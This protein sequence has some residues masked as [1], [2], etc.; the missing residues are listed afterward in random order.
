MGACCTKSKLGNVA[1]AEQAV[2]LSG[3]VPE[4]SPTRVVSH[5]SMGSASH[6]M[7][8]ITAE[9]S[10]VLAT[11]YRHMVLLPRDSR[12]DLSRCDSGSLDRSHSSFGGFGRCRG[13][14]GNSS[15]AEEG[16]GGEASHAH[17]FER[18]PAKRL[19]KAEEQLPSY[20]LLLLDD[21]GR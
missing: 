21:G 11:P 13:S 1:S 15:S 8:S 2:K 16:G 9:E 17:T 19:L 20:M 3:P 7:S 4:S 14:P 6:S 18:P 12:D 10:E 5:G